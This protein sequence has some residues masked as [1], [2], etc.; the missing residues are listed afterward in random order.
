MNADRKDDTDS[1][2]WGFQNVRAF[3]VFSDYSINKDSLSSYDLTFG[4]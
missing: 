2:S 4:G 1:V 3:V